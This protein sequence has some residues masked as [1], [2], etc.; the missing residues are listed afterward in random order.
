M[1]KINGLSQHLLAI[2]VILQVALYAALFLD[3][4]LARVVIGIAYLTFI[5][6]LI[7]I[8][9]LNQR[10]ET[11]ELIVYAA[12]FS[13]AFL[14]FAALLLNWVGPMVGMLFP[15]SVL[16]LSLVLNTVI[17]VAAA[18]T[19][20]RGGHQSIETLEKPKP[21]RPHPSYIVLTLIP[22][23]SVVGVYF[24]NTTGNNFY[25]LLTILSI[26]AVFVAGVFYKESPRVYPYAIAMIA[27][28][29]LFQTSLISNYLLSYGG[30]S[31]AELYVF[32]TAQIDSV[33]NPI[34]E[35]SPADQGMGRFNAMLSVTLLPTVYSNILGLD[36]TWVFK[37]VFPL[38][39]ALVP[40]G[41]YLLWQ[42]YIGKKFAFI[43]AFFLM[44]QATFFTE[45][46]ALNRQ[47]IAELFFV[48][49]LLLLMNKSMKQSTRF[50]GFGILGFALIFSHYALAVI[51]A[52]LILVAWAMSKWYLHR[53]SLNLK[54]S[55]VLFFF[56]AMFSWYIFTSGAVV[57]D[58]FMSFGTYVLSQLGGFFDPASRG[59]M[60]LTGLGLAESPSMLNTV[61]RVFA[62]L[63]ELFIAL[64]VVAFLAS[65]TRFR[66]DRDYAVFSI[67]AIVFLVALTIV[68]GLANTLNMTRFY[69]ILLIFLAPFCV[70]GMWTLA[71]YLMGHERVVVVGLLAVVILVP[72]FLFQTNF[73]YEVGGGDSWS[74]S[75]SQKTMDP[76]RLYGTLGYLDAYSVGSAVWVSDNL[77]YKYNL[78]SDAE[79]YTSLTAYGHLYRG[80]IDGLTN[81]T[82]LYPGEYVYLSYLSVNHEPQLWNGSLTP[83][84]NQTDLIY[85]N[86]GSVIYCVP[87]PISN[88]TRLS[89]GG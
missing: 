30:D 27:L 73:A 49:L 15:L 11:A 57:Y 47:M 16:P 63:T 60:V 45:M 33:W 1:S 83:L 88:E 44:A 79:L 80:Y 32:R 5:P 76:L 82:M 6:G 40:V 51:F 28:A 9:L 70:I 37:A 4:P 66:F 55:M 38:I 39:F 85:S 74:P 36:A 34:F 20:V 48:L 89:Y 10:F 87:G 21:W 84:L 26:V 75:L 67:V 7:F 17:L 77:P 59:S 2:V 3:I 31:P 25:L 23:L 12:G 29:L 13:I 52:V 35:I 69:H 41:A 8:K 18:F 19:Y 64:G 24:V 54:F 43:A 78:A 22:I 61:S 62:Y 68:P 50:L 53:P 46:T 58:S 86:G 81:V 56:V 42:P 14:M 65:K 71:R 72:Y